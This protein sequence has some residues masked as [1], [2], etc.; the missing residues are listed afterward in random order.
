MMCLG[1][2][3]SPS[4]WPQKAGQHR[5]GIFR[6]FACRRLKIEKERD[7]RQTILRSWPRLRARPKRR[8]LEVEIECENGGRVEKED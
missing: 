5:K 1:A 4:R 3:A 8:D 7:R 2:L 6:C